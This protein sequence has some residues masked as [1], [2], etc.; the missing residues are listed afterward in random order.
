[1]LEHT[2]EVVAVRRLCE[3]IGYGHL[4]SIASAL[5]RKKFIEKYGE[6]HATGAFVPTLSFLVQDEWQEVMK[7][8][9][10]F[11]DNLV[12]AALEGL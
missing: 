10:D 7:K 1:M 12:K 11:Y 9:L 5:W 3:Q 8:N 2:F 6:G 4:M